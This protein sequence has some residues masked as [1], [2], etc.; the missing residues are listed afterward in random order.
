MTLQELLA[1]ALKNQGIDATVAAAADDNDDDDDVTVEYS[2]QITA[3]ITSRYTADNITAVVKSGG[4]KKV[5]TITI[6]TSDAAL[7]VEGD[8]AH[9]LLS[10]MERVLED[11]SASRG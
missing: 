10:V 4:D 11:V 8:T 1:Q 6:E 2:A 9:D 3:Q 7:F 5:Q